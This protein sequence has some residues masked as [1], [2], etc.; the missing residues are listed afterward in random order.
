MLSFLPRAPFLF[1]LAAWVSS[2]VSG[3]APPGRMQA[4]QA[5]LSIEVPDVSN[6]VARAVAV[7]ERDGGQV[8]QFQTANG[9]RRG[10]VV[11]AQAVAVQSFAV[12]GLTVG[13]GYSGSNTEDALLGQNF[14]QHFEVQLLR[15]R[16]VLKPHR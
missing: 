16:M 12:T 14:L 9:V 6:S 7:A 4:W 11:K 15:D 13:V 1:C 2:C 8:A 3:A 10:R 5:G